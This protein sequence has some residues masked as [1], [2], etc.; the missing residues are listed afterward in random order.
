M[1]TKTIYLSDDP[2]IN[3]E[4]VCFNN[5]FN[6]I[7][8]EI[9]DSDDGTGYGSMFITLDKSTAIRFVKDLKRHIAQLEEEEDNA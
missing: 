3:H 9:T 7:F 1:R 8:I 2:K 5:T 6:R 4:L